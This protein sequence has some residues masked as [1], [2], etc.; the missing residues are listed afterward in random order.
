MVDVS[1]FQSTISRIP[2]SISLGSLDSR[3]FVHYRTPRT[4]AHLHHTWYLLPLQAHLVMSDAENIPE[5]ELSRVFIF[6]YLTCTV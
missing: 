1:I 6:C 2:S 5:V 4:S 3:L